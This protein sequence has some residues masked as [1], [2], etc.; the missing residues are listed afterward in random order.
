MKLKL[1]NKVHKNIIDTFLK[2]LKDQIKCL[3]AFSCF[4]IHLL[5]YY[6]DI[7]IDTYEAHCV[8]LIIYM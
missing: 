5:Q 1:L 6:M 3:K 2:Q 8:Q 4:K 7:Y